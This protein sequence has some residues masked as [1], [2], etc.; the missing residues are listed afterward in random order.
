MSSISSKWIGVIIALAFVELT[1]CSDEEPVPVNS[2]CP[3]G[4]SL[5]LS[6]LYDPGDPQRCFCCDPVR[7][8]SIEIIVRDAN[9]V[10]RGGGGASWTPSMP[11]PCGEGQEI[12]VDGLPGEVPLTIEVMVQCY[13]PRTPE[14]IPCATGSLYTYEVPAN[15]TTT[16]PCN[17]E[18][19]VLLPLFH[20][21]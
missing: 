16:L 10:S 6:F 8:N 21:F 17:G 2:P 7:A 18:A 13:S 14:N 11:Q 20:R 4:S 19:T 3:D 15:T 1:G 5:C 9:G 12:C